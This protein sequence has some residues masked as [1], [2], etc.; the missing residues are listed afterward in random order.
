M[1]LS[2]SH[3]RVLLLLFAVFFL[4]LLL[5]PLILYSLIVYPLSFSCLFHYFTHICLWGCLSLSHLSMGSLF[6]LVFCCTYNFIYF[7]LINRRARSF[8]LSFSLPFPISH[9]AAAA[10]P[11]CLCFVLVLRVSC[12]CC[13]VLMMSYPSTVT[14]CFAR[15]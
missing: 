7:F 11:C 6:C 15:I 9:A 10:A 8:S 3:H 5:Y 12:A 1:S 2:S 13:P 4:P 14:G